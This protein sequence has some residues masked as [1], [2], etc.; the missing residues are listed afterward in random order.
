MKHSG[1]LGSLKS[2]LRSKL[3]EQLRL[4]GEKRPSGPALGTAETRNRISYKI[5]VSLCADLMS[6]CDMPY[7]LSVFLPEAG[8]QEVLSK[9]E[10]VDVLALQTDDV[11]GSAPESTPL[12]LDIVERI[13]HHKSLAPGQ[14]SSYA[15]TEDV[16]SSIL[17]LD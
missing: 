7:A 9:Q 12:L 16:D 10:L 11:V 13:K 2:Q 14:I 4:K 5:A 1:V 17:T 3:Y 8:Q 6:K 15:Q